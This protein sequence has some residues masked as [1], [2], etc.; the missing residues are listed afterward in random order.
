[1]SFPTQAVLT[2]PPQFILAS[3]NFLITSSQA[4]YILSLE[5]EAADAITGSKDVTRHR[6]NWHILLWAWWTLTLTA[7]VTVV[8]RI[9][10]AMYVA[11]DLQL[12]HSWFVTVDLIIII[13]TAVGY[14]LLALFAG[15]AWKWNKVRGISF[16]STAA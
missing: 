16:P 7:L 14:G 3:I 12:N 10:P 9:I 1:M 6:T 8:L 5:K 4:Q 13:S 2:G 15:R 11:R